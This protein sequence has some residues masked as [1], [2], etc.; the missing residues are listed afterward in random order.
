[1]FKLPGGA[2]KTGEEGSTEKFVIKANTAQGNTCFFGPNSWYTVGHFDATTGDFVPDSEDICGGPSL[3]GKGKHFDQSGSVYASKRF[4]D[5]K[6]QRQIL[7]S[8]VKENHEGQYKFNATW[9]GIAG[10]PR[11]IT[12]RTG[13]VHGGVHGGVHCVVVSTT[14]CVQW[15]TVCRL[16]HSM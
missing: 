6:H 8:W 15:C 13:V 2:K 4:H 12:V 9:S 10:L 16:V 5:P 3:D 14:L 1:V 7:V 11:S